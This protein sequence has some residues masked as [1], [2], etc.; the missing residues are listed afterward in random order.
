MPDR[1]IVPF[2]GP[3]QALSH[4]IVQN[5]RLENNQIAFYRLQ[6]LGNFLGPLQLVKGDGWKPGC[7][8]N[9]SC[10]VG[11]RMPAIIFHACG[12][13][14]I[15]GPSNSCGEEARFPKACEVG[16]TVLVLQWS[17]VVFQH[18]PK[19]FNEN[20]KLIIMIFVGGTPKFYRL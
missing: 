20:S 1:E 15:G 11:G 5:D 10:D 4:N 6:G 14:A 13:V 8:E 19:Y 9:F 3:V 18:V 12:Q 16:S 2:E 7:L 17:V